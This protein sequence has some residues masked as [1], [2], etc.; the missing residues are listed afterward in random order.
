MWKRWWF[1][2]GQRFSGNCCG[3]GA[4]QEKERTPLVLPHSRLV[5][6]HLSYL[7]PWL[8]HFCSTPCK[9]PVATATSFCPFQLRKSK[10]HFLGLAPNASTDLKHEQP[11][12]LNYYKFCQ[13]ERWRVLSVNFLLWDATFVSIICRSSF[14][15]QSAFIYTTGTSLA[16]WKAESYPYPIAA[17]FHR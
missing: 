4:Y 8:T 9:I 7:G 15:E 13:E 10:K 17:C 1:G 12:S 16:S 2:M 14:P 3:A 11:R 6:I 5:R